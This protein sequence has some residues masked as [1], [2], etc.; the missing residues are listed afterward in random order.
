MLFSSLFLIP[1]TPRKSSKIYPLSLDQSPNQVPVRFR[2]VIEQTLREFFKAIQIGKDVDPSWK[3]Q[4]YKVI[5]RLDDYVPEIF[6]TRAFLDQLEW[7]RAE[8]TLRFLRGKTSLVLIHLVYFLFLWFCMLVIILENSFWVWTLLLISVSSIFLG[9]G[10][11]FA[12]RWS[13]SQGVFRR[14]P[15]RKRRRVLLEETNLQNHRQI[16]RGHPGELQDA[17]IPQAVGMNMWLK[18]N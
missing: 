12:S 14:R 4:I 11:L 13:H 8:R 7:S 15:R 5:A 10:P 17:S 9:P 18:K 6:K 3:K 2:W 1:S 16:R